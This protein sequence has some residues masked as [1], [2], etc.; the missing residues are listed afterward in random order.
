MAWKVLNTRD[1]PLELHLPERLLILPARGHGELTD[2]EVGEAQVLALA[3]RHALALVEQEP[4]VPVAPAANPPAAEATPPGIKR[5]G[6]KR[7]GR[8]NKQLE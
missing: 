1:Q 4:A 6:R 5:S 2:S 8:P 7:S 3:R